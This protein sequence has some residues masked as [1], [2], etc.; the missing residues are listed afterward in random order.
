LDITSEENVVFWHK[1]GNR[2][3]A[4]FCLNAGY[5]NHYPDFLIHTIFGNIILIETKGNHLLN[6][7]NQEKDKLGTR[8]ASMVGNQYKY[9]RVSETINTQGYYTFDS[10]KN[11]IK[12]L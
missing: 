6:Q 1:F 10:I 5:M 8:W 4:N 9:F 12:N 7:D 11:V 3:A 2:G